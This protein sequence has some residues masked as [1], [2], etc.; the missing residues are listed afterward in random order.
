[1]GHARLTGRGPVRAAPRDTA[2]RPP[3][4]RLQTPKIPFFS[5]DRDFPSPGA[6]P[7]TVPAQIVPGGRCCQP[8]AGPKPPEGGRSG[9]RGWRLRPKR[10]SGPRRGAGPLHRKRPGRL[11]AAVAD[12]S[13]W[14]SAGHQHRHQPAAT[15]PAS[16]FLPQEGPRALTLQGPAPCPH[17]CPRSTL[18][19]RLTG[20]PPVIK[21]PLRCRRWVLTVGGHSPQ[22]PSRY[23]MPETD[24]P[25][26]EDLV[27]AKGREWLE[28]TAGERGGSRPRPEWPAGG[29]RRPPRQVP[30]ARGRSP[31]VAIAAASPDLLYLSLA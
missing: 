15:R 12:H 9:R 6:R 22:V 20:L 2:R 28:R 19:T 4:C 23:E 27:V 31:P 25:G 18:A 21:D 26:R 7:S 10:G 30:Q 29:R 3:V 8:P 24:S 16:G 1:M 17:H 14:R 5:P 13:G 11:A